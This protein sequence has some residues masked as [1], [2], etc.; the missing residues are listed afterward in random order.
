MRTLAEGAIPLA[1][2]VLSIAYVVMKH[3]SRQ[4]SWS[5]DPQLHLPGR[6]RA[7]SI[8]SSQGILFHP[9]TVRSARPPTF[10]AGELGIIG[11]GHELLAIKRYLAT[12]TDGLP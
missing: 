7:T 1:P 2:A 8:A 10:A 11:P 3:P 5:N 12:R 9:L 4:C 6:R